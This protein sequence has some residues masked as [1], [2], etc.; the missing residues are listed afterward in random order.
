M[1]DG[2]IGADVLTTFADVSVEDMADR[3]SVTSV[4]ELE[5]VE[6]TVYNESGTAQNLFNSNG[7]IALNN[8]ILNDEASIGNLILQFEEFLNLIIAKFNTSPKKYSFRV[9]ILPTTI[10]NYKDLAKSYKE[11]TTLGYSKMLP[12]IALGQ[13]QSSILATAHFENEILNLSEILVPPMSSNTMSGKADSK[14]SDKKTEPDTKEKTGGREEK[15]DNEKSEKTIA[16]RES[17]N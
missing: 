14:G 4:D 9:Q 11:L 12:M 16:N 3:S 5:K 2:L 1:L 10:Y 6:R 15:P 8:S 13:S 7:N 17:M